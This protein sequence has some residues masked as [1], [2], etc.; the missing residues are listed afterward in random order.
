M[1]VKETSNLL[2]QERI[3]KL[4]ENTDFVS[5]LLES[6]V[7]YA[8]IAADFDGNVI[9]Y[10]EGAR[11]IYGYAPEEVIGKQTIDIFFPR[12]FIEARK[13]QEIVD[14][15]IEKGGFSYEGEKV[16]KDGESFPA[17]ILFTLTKDKSGKVVG[18][19]EI[20]ADLTERKRAAELGT[21]ASAAKLANQTKSDF[22]A[23]MSHELR[24]PL[25]AVIG[26]AQVLQEQYFGQLNEKQA[27]Y[28]NDILESGRHLVSLINDILD[29]SK[30]ESG[31]E[32]LEF[33]SVGIKE[34]VESSL[35][36]IREKVSKHGISLN[37]RAVEDIN[38]LK[39][40]A[41]ERKVR[42]IVF[43][44]LSNA[45]KFT[46]DG[47]S[48]TVEVKKEAE[49]VIIS[50]LDTG[51]GIAPE[52]QKKL[53]QRFYQ[54]H[55]GTTDKTPGTGLGLVIAKE[56]TEIQGGRI[57]VESEGLGRGSRFS[58]TLPVHRIGGEKGIER[59]EHKG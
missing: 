50:V 16:R 21:E 36:M 48:I 46:P 51:V 27:E 14:G 3:N 45:A 41:D 11:Q 37:A 17:Q 54:V 58:F 31:K 25:N 13:L 47:G 59:K 23:S 26:F 10:N 5:T 22:L 52:Q 6:L 44:L 57:W 38:G 7:G 1:T 24:T 8:I 42:Q 29:L 28:V 9:A 20:V 15:L 32:T 39:I 18:F 40:S 35:L 12:E 55:S 19:I 30:I 43:N 49:E 4:R 53:F 2:I 56:L 34:L 33:S